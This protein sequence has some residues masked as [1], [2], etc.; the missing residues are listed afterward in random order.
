MTWTEAELDD[1][2][3]RIATDVLGLDW[4][5]RFRVPTKDGKYPF[6]LLKPFQPSRNL[7]QMEKVL[8]E[9]SGMGWM[10]SIRQ[11]LNFK[12]KEKVWLCEATS[13]PKGVVPPSQTRILREEKTI[14]LAVIGELQQWVAAQ[15]KITITNDNYPDGGVMLVSPKEIDAV[16]V[17]WWQMSAAEQRRL[18]Y[19]F[20]ACMNYNSNPYQIRIS[21]I[22]DVY[23]VEEGSRDGDHWLWVV[24]TKSGLYQA[25]CV[26]GWCDYTGW[27]CQSGSEWEPCT[28]DEAMSKVRGAGLVWRGLASESAGSGPALPQTTR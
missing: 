1:I 12:T 9:L 27:D 19:D 24:V 18:D 13:S 23:R 28:E 3:Y 2:D 10:F 15:P 14:S 26:K 7:E 25:Y 17:A 21:D 5:K 4:D 6:G 11:G 16:P 22:Q 20:V 8:N